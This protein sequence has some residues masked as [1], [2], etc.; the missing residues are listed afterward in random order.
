M[1]KTR[2]HFIFLH[3][4]R[5]QR[6]GW[7]LGMDAMSLVASYKLHDAEQVRMQNGWGKR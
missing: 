3:P 6:L 4:E 2:V 5:S 7:R 1:G